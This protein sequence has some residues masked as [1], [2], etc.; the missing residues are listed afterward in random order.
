MKIRGRKSLPD[1]GNLWIYTD[2][3]DPEIPKSTIF[4]LY[5]FKIVVQRIRKDLALG[6]FAKPKGKLK[7]F[8]EISDN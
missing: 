8:F 3:M 4:V 7:A 1:R 5:F 2:Y 6:I